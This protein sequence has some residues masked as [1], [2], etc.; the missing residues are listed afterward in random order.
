[1][2]VLLA[3]RIP[4]RFFRYRM[5]TKNMGN[6]YRIRRIVNSSVSFSYMLRRPVILVKTLDKPMVIKISIVTAIC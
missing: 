5:L 1:M 6:K 3:R 2:P 4:Q